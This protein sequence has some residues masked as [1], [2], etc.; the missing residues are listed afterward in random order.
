MLSFFLSVLSSSAIPTENMNF[1]S[2]KFSNLL[3]LYI[4]KAVAFIFWFCSQ[5][6]DSL[7]FIVLVVCYLFIS[8]VF[9]K[10]KSYLLQTITI[11]PFA[12]FCFY[13]LFLF[14]SAQTSWMALC[15]SE[16]WN[17]IPIVYSSCPWPMPTSLTS[18]SKW[19]W[20]FR[21]LH[22]LFDYSF[23]VCVEVTSSPICSKM[24]S[25]WEIFFFSA[26]VLNL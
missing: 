13:F 10:R 14:P 7:Y 8:L 22:H 20:D 19:C 3:C 5:S 12:S 17:C 23:P 4:I 24:L 15:Y 9:S 6:L 1:L 26:C 21:E 11:L 25:V 16:M 18:L 2:I